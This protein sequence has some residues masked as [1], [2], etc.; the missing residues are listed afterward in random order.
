[1]L[2]HMFERYQQSPREHPLNFS[3]DSMKQE[4]GI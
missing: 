2:E 1:M 4:G 3:P